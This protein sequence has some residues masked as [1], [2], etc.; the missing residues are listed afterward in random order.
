VEGHVD[1]PALVTV[2]A[3]PV[4]QGC[5]DQPRPLIVQ[6]RMPAARRDD[7]R[8]Q[9]GRQLPIIVFFIGA[10]KGRFNSAGFEII[11]ELTGMVSYIYTN[12][13]LLCM[14]NDCWR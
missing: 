4:E 14:Q 13:T 5:L 11:P 10:I 2:L 1:D 6:Q 12:Q 7:L 9:H 8:Q 3:A